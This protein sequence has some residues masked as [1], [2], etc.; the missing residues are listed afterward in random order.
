MKL[1]HVSD[2]HLGRMS[3]NE[4]RE[5]DH[6][7]VLDEIDAIAKD[8]G[9]DLILHTGDLFDTARPAVPDLRLAS[10]ALFSLGKLAPVVVLLGNH[11]S[12]PLFRLLGHLFGDERHVTFVDQPRPPD[13]GGILT[14]GTSSGETIRLACVPF[15]SA[16][17]AL[18]TFGDPGGWASGYSDRIRQIQSAL[19]RGLVAGHDGAR[20]I[21]LFAAHLHVEGALFSGSE[22]KLHVGDAYATQVSQLPQVAY[23]AFGHIHRPQALPSSNV[24]GRYAGSPL[25]LDFGE[26]AEEKSVVVVEC[27]PGRPARVETIPLTKGRRLVRVEGSLDEI[28][29]QKDKLHGVLAQIRVVTETR[30]DRLADRLHDLLPGTVIVDAWDVVPGQDQ[31][32]VSRPAAGDEPGLRELFHAYLDDVPTLRAGRDRA[33]AVFEELLSAEEGERTATFDEERLLSGSSDENVS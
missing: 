4:P 7:A 2:W 28:A 18:T 25:A 31:H 8:L 5:Q 6:R 29:A 16:T 10:D 1:L 27:T 17:R 23:A 15:V 32:R 3:G 21:L 20:E 30:I 9:P 19:G 13:A 11:D 12:Q 14:L 26:A 24:T 33:K 22:K